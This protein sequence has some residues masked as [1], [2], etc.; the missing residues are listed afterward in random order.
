MTTDNE[1]PVGPQGTQMFDLDD[2]NKMVA[3]EIANAYSPEAETPALIGV[4]PNVSG[5]Q[6]ILSKDKIEVGRRPNSDIT[7]NVSSVSSM[8]AQIIK[9]DSQ[10]KLLNLLSSNGTFINGE[11]V[12]ERIIHKGDRVAFADAEFVFTF[13]DDPVT[14]EKS[15][16][17]IGLLIGASLA[18]VAIAV[19]LYYFMS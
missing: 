2:V 11:K 13:I 10:W 8:H 5:Q 6:F 7:L 3:Q 16:P 17:L 14:E 12:V 15:S 9:Q 4:S 1:S 19:G 18:V